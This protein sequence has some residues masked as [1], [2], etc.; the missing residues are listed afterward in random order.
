MDAA[1]SRAWHAFY[2]AVALIVAA[3]GILAAVVLAATGRGGEM[4]RGHPDYAPLDLG[5]VTSADVALLR[6][7]TAVWGYS[8]RFTDDALE[9]IAQA[10]TDR[11]VQIATLQRRVAELA[12]A[13]AADI[14]RSPTDGRSEAGPATR[15]D[16]RS[17]SPASPEAPAS[18]GN[19]T[20]SV[21][22]GPA[23]DTE[24][25]S[26][27]VPGTEST[28]Q[29]APMFPDTQPTRAETEPTREPA[30]RQES[31]AGQEE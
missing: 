8:T 9:Q 19:F 10:L 20:E 28:P 13:P 30:S 2:V 12:A 15:G 1:R 29:E 5:P 26:G 25:R 22:S 7:P 4:S 17:D 3:A 27:Q 31:G 23:P 14:R 16:E 21:R 6:P 11:D 18:S 24:P